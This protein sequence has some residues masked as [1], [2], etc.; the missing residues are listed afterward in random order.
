M[1]KHGRYWPWKT[2]S[3]HLKSLLPC[4]PCPRP[5]LGSNIIVCAVLFGCCKEARPF[6]LF[7]CFSWFLSVWKYPNVSCNLDCKTVRI[8]RIQVRASSQ[9]KGLERAEN[10]ERDWG[11]TLSPHTRSPHTR[12]RALQRARKTLTPRFTDFFTDSEKK[13]RLFCSL[14]A[15][16]LQYDAF[17]ASI[18]HK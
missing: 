5:G 18:K 13:T 16:L 9:T 15:I 6:S 8:L 17:K 2:V 7:L 10:R 3:S 12:S 14:L 11:E 1:L 4:N